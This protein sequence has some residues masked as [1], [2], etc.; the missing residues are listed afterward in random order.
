M[1]TVLI[2]YV[3]IRPG[4]GGKLVNQDVWKYF[5][6]YVPAHFDDVTLM[7]FNPQTLPN[8]EGMIEELNKYDNIIV[9]GREPLKYLGLED[10][11]IDRHSQFNN[12][13]EEIISDESSDEEEVIEDEDDEEDSED[14]DDEEESESSSDGNDDDDDEFKVKKIQ[15]VR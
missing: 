11:E 12:D 14:D 13:S 4:K 8:L 5:E 6:K 10:A 1:S 7:L 15:K 3:N 2:G 9:T